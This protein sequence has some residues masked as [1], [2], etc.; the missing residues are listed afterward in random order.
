MQYFLTH[1]MKIEQPGRF[2]SMPNCREFSFEHLMDPIGFLL[3][4]PTLFLFICCFFISVFIHITISHK[5]IDIDKL[6]S[7]GWHAKN[8]FALSQHL[9]RLSRVFFCMPAIVV[10]ALCI[11]CGFFMHFTSKILLYII[12]IYIL[13]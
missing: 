12:Y 11:R 2:S 4:F 10:F 8:V 13:N 7:P 6:R 9:S 1:H 3:C 5:L